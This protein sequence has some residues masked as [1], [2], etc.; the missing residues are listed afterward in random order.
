[1]KTFT[2]TV[3]TIISFTLNLFG[4]QPFFVQLSSTNFGCGVSEVTA[5]SNCSF[6]GTVSVTV[7]NTPPGITITNVSNVVAGN[8]TFN[9]EVTSAAPIFAT[10]EFTIITTNNPTGCPPP[11][12]KYQDRIM[13]NCVCNLELDLFLEHESCNL[14]NNGFA[15]ITTSGGSGVNNILWSNGQTGTDAGPFE[16]GNYTVIVGDTYG[17][18]D[19]AS[20]II[21]QYVCSGLLNVEVSSEDESCLS[22]NNG[23]AIAI[24][25]GGSGQYTYVWSNGSS[26]T[27][28]GPLA[29]GI[30]QIQVTDID[31]CS[32]TDSIIIN[33]YIC[34]GYT[35][36]PS[37]EEVVCYGEC[38]GIVNLALSNG[39]QNFLAFWNDGNTE[40]SRENLCAGTYLINIT[41][42][43]NCVASDTVV[44]YQPELFS[45]GEIDVESSENG[46]GGV[47]TI[48]Y[49]GGQ[50][51][52]DWFING[53]EYDLEDSLAVNQM[54]FSD[55]EPSCYEILGI[56]ENGCQLITDSICVD[57]VSAISDYRLGEL[58]LFPNPAMDI[59][60]LKNI[61]IQDHFSL[62]IT[63]IS[64]MVVYKSHNEKMINISTLESGIYFVTVTTNKGIY[65]QKLIKI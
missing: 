20:F 35:I 31:Q 48:N 29:P 43:D 16:P 50:G 62:N 49:T 19:T 41:D 37:V 15:T 23:S 12:A 46:E 39:S 59:V 64:G 2:I 1:M 61:D 65:S 13:T 45:F 9:V 27:N 4:Q 55:L 57:N 17:C 58:L 30:Y 38:N 18:S 51:E 40:T 53:N 5:V 47:I 14:C 60:Y 36:V 26:S 7:L 54:V 25:G 6:N 33:P 3:F 21:E 22:C 56:D 63:N 10:L 24:A 8:F 42:A 44:V 32:T 11:G 52:I 28:P 34:P